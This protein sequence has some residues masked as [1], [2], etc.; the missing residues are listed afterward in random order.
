MEIDY[1]VELHLNG[2]VT[3]IALFAWSGAASV[4]I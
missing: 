3:A 2:W 4:W 1:A